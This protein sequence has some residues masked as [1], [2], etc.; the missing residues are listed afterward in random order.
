MRCEAGA[1]P[2]RLEAGAGQARRETRAEM[3]C[4]QPR[5]QIIAAAG[6]IADNQ[7]DRPALVEIGD[8]IGVRMQRERK[9]GEERRTAGA[10]SARRT[11]ARAMAR[12]GL[13][14]PLA[15]CRVVVR[16]MTQSPNLHAWP[17]CTR[18]TDLDN[19]DGKATSHVKTLSDV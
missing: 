7:G 1:G 5:E 9:A 3:A 10:G 4:H 11:A 13:C 17:P 2:A 19:S 18:Q 14:Y 15:G 12:V 8:R 6:P 16:D